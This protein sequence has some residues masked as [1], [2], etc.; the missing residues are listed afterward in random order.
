MDTSTMFFKELSLPVKANTPIH[1]LIL[2]SDYVC[3][4]NIFNWLNILFFI[5]YYL[6][7]NDY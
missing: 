3:K 5:L 7:D 1:V 4:I 6:S 2:L